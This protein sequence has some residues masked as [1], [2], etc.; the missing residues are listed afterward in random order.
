MAR[1]PQPRPAAGYPGTG[2]PPGYGPGTAPIP[3]RTPHRG[4]PV[5][6]PVLAFLALLLVGGGSF[7]LVNFLNATVDT[8][9]A[10]ASL[11]PQTLTAAVADPTASPTEA[12]AP[13]ATVEPGGTEEPTEP[14]VSS[15][16]P[17]EEGTPEPITVVPPSD[18]AAD[19]PG[20]LLFTRAGG[21]IWAASGKTMSPL[22]NSSSTKADSTPVWSPDGKSIYFIRSTKHEVNAGKARREGKYTL[23][24]TDL[25]RMRADGSKKQLVF[26]SLIKDS[27]GEWF[28]TVLQ[29]SVSPAGNNV[30]V[31][32]DGPD[33]EADGVELYIID[34]KRGSMRKV[35]VPSESTGIIRLGHNDPDFSADGRQLAFT[36]NAADGSAAE[37]RIGILDCVTKNNCTKG[38][39]KLIATG[40]A[41][42]SWSPDGKLLA[43]EA[44]DGNGRDIAIITAKGG[45][46]RV[47]LTTDGNSFAPEFSP[48]G[49][50]IAY[51]KRDGQDIN[52]RVMTLDIGPQGKITLVDDRP[53]TSDGAVDGDSGLSWYIPAKQRKTTDEAGPAASDEATLD[54]A[55]LDEAPP[56]P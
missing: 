11:D 32:S 43:V 19:V 39:S 21:D 36:Y 41:D 25:M 27:R 28:S 16:E 10:E 53:V 48:N 56:V 30:A 23:Y 12:S 51:L 37:P 6:A 7:F 47:R 52:V 22:S 45:N 26:K 54:P 4:T 46:E 34:S 42:P 5:V 29:P 55:V 8:A 17:D 35:N 13:D 15:T 33:G 49:D 20:S 38:K 40:F 44:T 31:V 1:A 9:A 18:E 50:Q 3:P 14:P 24:P 2:Y